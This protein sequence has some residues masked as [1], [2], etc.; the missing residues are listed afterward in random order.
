MNKKT[1]FFAIIFSLF[2]SNSVKAVEPE[3]VVKDEAYT[4]K[5]VSQSVS[6]PIEIE[7][8]STKTVVIKFKNTGTAIWNSSGSRF[9]SA[10]TMEPR[11]RVSVFKGKN[12]TSGKQTGK[13]SAQVKPGG[14]VELSI[15]L[16]APEKTGEY[17]EKFYLAAE[18]YSWVKN[19]YFYFKI[20][21]VPKKIV[22]TPVENEIIP[23]VNDSSYVAKRLILS[24]KS[25][26][27][28]GG[29]QTKIVIGY[30]NNG[31]NTWNKYKLT[32]EDK[33]YFDSTWGSSGKV[34]EKAEEI[35]PTK[36]LRETFYFRIPAKKGDYIAKFK[37]EIDEGKF[38]DEINIPITVTADAPDDYQVSELE[39]E[40]EDNGVIN[41][42]RLENEPRV[43]VGITAPETNF[44]QFRSYDDDYNVFD[45]NKLQGVLAKRK[46]AVIKYNDGEY[47]FKGGDLDF[48]S[49]NFIRLEPITNSHAIFHIP[50]LNTRVAKWVDP[51]KLFNKYRGA[52]EYRQGTVD[53]KMYIV[54]DV[55]LEDYVKGMAEVGRADPIEFI[56]A[57]LVA[58]RNYAYI[59]K[60]KYPFFDVVA[61]TY[62]QLYLGFEAEE[63]LP[64]VVEAQEAT[65]GMFVTYNNEVVTT[66]YFGN[67]N[68]K[69]K[70]FSSVWGG[71][72]KPWLVSVVADYDKGKKLFGHGVGMSQRDAN[73]RAKNEGLNFVGLLKHYYTGVK[74][75]KL[76]E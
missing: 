34:L 29:E 75:E 35:L 49:D 72:N 5:Y 19:G 55:L 59:A 17:I 6:D 45:G 52:V 37:L 39:T 76:Y 7:A 54:N 62:D 20:K 48:D 69:T 68:G 65:R 51:N 44:I 71:A 16:Q 9:I 67:S 18:N 11:D 43:R 41:N 66:P 12:W 58:A 56:K 8:G 23:S 26:T 30:Q 63:V 22:E 14:V 40:V 10:Y 74:V 21:V 60:N 31:K 42:I 57:N 50:N 47:N 28:P 38:I 27:A 36:F 70:S 73:L 4:A 13:I 2:L 3:V 25:V 46:F 24:K 33:N 64:M 32:N 15:D 61:N 1:I 53:K